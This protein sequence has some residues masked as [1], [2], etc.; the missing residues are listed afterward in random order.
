M[1]PTGDQQAA[2]DALYAGLP[3]LQ[4][5]RKCQQ[6]CGPVAGMDAEVSRIYAIHGRRGLRPDLQCGYLDPNGLC[7][8]YAARPLV[9]RLWG[10]VEEMQ[11]PHGCEPER[12]LTNAE[13]EKLFEEIGRIAGEPAVLGWEDLLE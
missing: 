5:Q 7:I 1:S 3:S 6:W 11:C 2:L 12:L 13:V 4:C 8:A 10:I 9:C